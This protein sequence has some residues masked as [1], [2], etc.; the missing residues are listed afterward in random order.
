V[1]LSRLAFQAL[2]GRRLTS[3]EGRHVVGSRRSIQLRRDGFGVAYVDAQDEADAWFGLGF[4]HGQDRG[5][6]LEVTRRLTRGLLA[7]VLGPQGLAIDRAVRLIGVHRA[8][9]AQLETFDADV[10]DQLAAYT[11][12]INA[13]FECE[14]LPRS[15]EHALLRSAPVAWE[16]V[17]VVAFGLLMCCFLP[18]NW[19]V[20]L[21]RLI[22]ATRD[23]EAAVSALDPGWRADFPL[24]HPP[25]AA[26]GPASELFLARDLQALREFLGEAGAGGS[27]AWAVQGHKSAT[28]RALLCNDP[29]LPAALPNLG[30]L[31]R[32]K[33]PSFA[34]A[35]ISIVGI[36]AFITGHNGHA[37]WGSTSAQVDN[38]DLF[39]EELSADGKSYRQ[40]DEWRACE[41]RLEQIPVKGAAPVELRVLATARGAI[42]ARTG[43]S[44]ASIFE[45]VPKLGRGNAL[46]LSATWLARRPTRS[47]LTFHQV[48]SFDQFREA[49]AKSAGCAY[50][51]IYA[52]RETIGWVLAAEVPR[53]RSGFG[54]LPLAGWLAEVGWD[55]I[56]ASDELPWS[57]NPEAGFVCCA[58]NKPVADGESQV[59]LGHDFLDGF[60][61]RRIAEELGRVN[62][63][64]VERMAALQLDVQSLAFADVRPALLALDDWDERL[65]R[66]AKQALELLRAWDGRVSGDSAAASV[67][68]LFV[69][70]LNRRV[71]QSKAPNSYL[72]ASG[73]GVMKLIPGT[74]FNSRRASFLARLI[75]EQPAGYFAAWHRELEEAL[76][77]AITTL[78][79]RFGSDPEAWGWGK[80]RQITLRHR[81]GDKKP[82]GEIFNLGPLPGWGDGTT[83]NQAGIEFWEPLRHPNVTAHLR[84]VIDIGNWGA[85]RFVLLGGQSGNP[86][87]PHYGDLVPLYLRGEG[88]PVHWDDE[89]VHE[90][91]IATT[92][93]L[94]SMTKRPVATD[95]L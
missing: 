87:S 72:Y 46:S 92:T 2:L 18:S 77:E 22:I 36:P 89:A 85:S 21:A 23:G 12:G 47:L 58:N 38:A 80:I 79:E 27:N 42:V 19:D 44:E 73:K 57:R 4:C 86:L 48:R 56:A 7:E 93:L 32:V 76:A 37:A 59:F 78:R 3:Y 60:R 24:T 95:T 28:G 75:T 14:A 43:D 10:R 5:G 29:H 66:K 63:W 30:Y 74:C 61:Q 1:K 55:G 26:A 13:A 52:D 9:S 17:D 51:L 68:E 91:A 50:S 90:H 31:T 49:C 84:S 6:Q 40:G 83:V 15:H 94:P 53:R 81:F 54:S 35:G 8:A 71:C 70:A 16:P 67:F 45:P 41:E 33:C 69:G 34:V 25:G 64:T 82:L 62:D 88:V 39:L 65:S 11:A 20:E